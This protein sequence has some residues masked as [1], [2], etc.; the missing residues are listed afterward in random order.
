MQDLM[1]DGMYQ[2]TLEGL[3]QG[4]RY[5]AKY[6]NRSCH[7][8]PGAIA[9]IKERTIRSSASPGIRRPASSWWSTAHSM[10]TSTSG[11]APLECSPKRSR[12]TAS[13]LHALPL[14]AKTCRLWPS[15]PAVRRQVV[16]SGGAGHRIH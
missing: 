3:D 5:L 15:G 11:Y 8:S 16:G 12:S 1:E 10:A 4:M 2:L 13:H 14:S 6:C 9:T 7:S